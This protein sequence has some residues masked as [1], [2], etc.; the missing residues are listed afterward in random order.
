M[1]HLGG[2]VI[3]WWILVEWLPGPIFQWS[4]LCI[5]LVDCHQGTKGFEMPNVKKLLVQ[6]H[7]NMG[8]A[9]II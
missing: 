3:A 1:K 9:W 8:S 5:S 6:P 4:T 2:M 7:G